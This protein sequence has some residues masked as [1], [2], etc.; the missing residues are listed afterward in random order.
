MNLSFSDIYF[1]K[2]KKNTMYNF[3]SFNAVLLENCNS[4]SFPI[5]FQLVKKQSLLQI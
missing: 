1:W 3:E 4:G 2:V 5:F